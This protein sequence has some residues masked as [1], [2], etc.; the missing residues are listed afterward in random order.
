[1]LL[2][3]VQAQGIKPL[4][5]GDPVP[6]IVFHHI[7]NYKTADARLSGLRGKLV[8]LDFF[9]TWCG[10]CIP[11]VPRLDSLQKH[12]GDSLQ[13]VVI[14][15][16]VST[17][18]VKNFI[19]KK[20][21]SANIVLPFVLAD[22]ILTGLFPHTMIPHEIWISPEGTVKAVTSDEAVTAANIGAMLAGKAVQLPFKS[23]QINFHR[24]APLLTDGNGGSASRA[25]FRSLLTRNLNGVPGA[26]G[27]KKD[28]ISKT[29]RY[30]FLN[31]SIPDLYELALNI[32]PEETLLQ[33]KD[34]G[35]FIYNPASGLTATEWYE[36]NAYC[37]ELTVPYTISIESARKIMVDDLNRYL[38]LNAHM[39]KRKTKCWALIKAAV[40]SSD[41]TTQHSQANPYLIRNKTTGEI[42]EILSSPGSVIVDE[43]GIR[44][45]LSLTLERDSLGDTA[46]LRRQLLRYG[47]DLVPAERILDRL[48]ITDAHSDSTSFFNADNHSK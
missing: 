5:I 43:T 44:D 34:S 11:V 29:M 17:A 10:S 15:Q 2:S 32:S 41:T 37:Y 3:N 28:S 8:I 46:A 39:E 6:D 35:R 42:A 4:S 18:H 40:K 31:R 23:D 19:T 25:V 48:V 36:K 13:V 9:G 14:C 1:M 27:R 33:T 45:S 47:L 26:S 38:G 12:F 7:I 22:S 30:Y 21:G 16:D 20:W 24:D